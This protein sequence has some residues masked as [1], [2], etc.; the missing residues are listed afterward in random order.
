MNNALFNKAMTTIIACPG[1]YSG[2]FVLPD[3]VTGIG[4]NAF[5]SC[6][7]L[8]TVTIQSGVT[9]IGYSA[10]RGC[11]GLTEI[12]IPDS[13]TS[14]GNYAFEGCT[15]LTEITIPDSVTGIGDNA[16][17]SCTKLTTVTIQS[18]ATSIGHSAFRGCTG[19]TEIT[20]PDSVTSIGTSAFYGCTGLTEITIPDSMTSIGTSAFYG[21]TGLTEITIPDS[22][23]SIGT[24]AFYSCTGLT[25]ITIP[26]SVNSIGISAF[27]G[28]SGLT[29]VTIPAGVNSIGSSAFRYC[30]SLRIV[31]IPD[32]V[33]SIGDYAF[34]GCSSLADIYYKG[35]DWDDVTKGTDAIPGGC[36]VHY[37]ATAYYLQ[38]TE[39]RPDNVSGAW[40]VTSGGL[41]YEDGSILYFAVEGDIGGLPGE[42]TLTLSPG[43]YGCTGGLYWGGRL[44]NV[45][46]DA[47]TEYTFTGSADVHVDL[48]WYVK[49]ARH[50]VTYDG[51][52][53]NGA[54]TAQL[55][56]H[57]GS[58]RV[59]KNG[60]S[61][62]NFFT[63]WNTAADGSGME[64]QPN[65]V[66]G[67]IIADITLYA[68]WTSAYRLSFDRNKG[69]GSM[70]AL[71]V[72]RNGNDA[73]RTVTLPECGF[74]NSGKALKEWNTSNKDDGTGTSY[75]P[76]TTLTLTEDTKLYAI[77]DRAWTVTFDANGG[78][79]SAFTKNVVQGRAMTL[80]ACPF[81][82]E[83]SVF[84]GW[85]T[86][87]D[88]TGTMVAAG[89]AFAPTAHTTLYA[90]WAT[91][92][93]GTADLTLPDGPVTIAESAFEND[94]RITS[95][96]AHTCTAIG[97]NA[98]K[99]CI[100]LTKIRLP[101]N[102]TIADSAFDNTA[103]ETIF[104]PADGTTETWANTNGIDFVAE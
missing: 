104:A 38:V 63:G 39:S 14:I 6:T 79:G 96:D 29:S 10:F 23:N 71:L 70:D 18:G 11:T 80:P 4:D 12:T 83:H 78:T 94:V 21:C 72:P 16:F 49:T 62:N 52:G 1:G 24:Y 89:D 34:S 30:S 58:V 15:G 74:T 41:S 2:V 45:I 103:L 54:M 19:L 66:I 95:V 51:N 67:N 9:S 69:S 87:A 75:Q 17:R 31:T 35:N 81:N 13:V 25:S 5:R 44:L 82:R 37:N 53:C 56:E 57:N 33:N 3:S 60:F 47:V 97:A 93:F 42:F 86:L 43:S 40:S 46:T 88:G 92:P 50:T 76:G 102:C 22:V 100:R 32:S 20:I 73:A 61:G 99:G 77:W 84:T 28:C 48:T 26:D 91:I 55:V 68:Q 101:K 98:F 27:Q 64:Y 7:K 90:Q 8:T 36:A 65:A 85:N 59:S